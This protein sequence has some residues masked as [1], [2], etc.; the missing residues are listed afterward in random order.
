[1]KS[2][3]EKNAVRHAVTWIVIYVSLVNIGGMISEAV[4]I[5]DSATCALLIMLSLLLLNY[6][7]KNNW[8][9]RLGLRKITKM[10]IKRSLYYVPLMLLALLQLANGIDSSLSIIELLIVCLMMIGVGFLE[11][12]IF[13]GFLMQAILKKSGINR[14]ILIS[15]ITFG[16]GHI[17]NIARGYGYFELVTQIIAT[18]GIGIVLA[19]LAAIT[20]NIVPGILFHIVFNISG[21]ISNVASPNIEMYTLA[22]ILTICLVYSLNLI[23][24]LRSEELVAKGNEQSA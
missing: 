9:E 20:K 12:V 7:S 14:A 2:S 18:A 6:L 5:K 1:M 10:D 16:L 4:G 22:A 24:Y 17:V 15:G 23:R 21:S 8:I 3:I 13:R 11:E 19:M